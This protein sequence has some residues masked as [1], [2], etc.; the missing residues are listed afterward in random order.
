MNLPAGLLEAGDDKT[1]R[2]QRKSSFVES[3]LVVAVFILT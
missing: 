3:E 1:I 2:F